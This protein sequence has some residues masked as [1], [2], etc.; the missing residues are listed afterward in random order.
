MKNLANNTWFLV[1]IGAITVINLGSLFAF[2]QLSASQNTESFMRRGQRVQNPSCMMAERVGFDEEQAVRFNQLRQEH[3]QEMRSQRNDLSQLRNELVRESLE[4]EVNEEKV[5]VLIQDL[6]Q[7]H[8][9]RYRNQVQ[10]FN[11]VKGVCTPKQRAE[12]RKFM[13]DVADRMDRRGVCGQQNRRDG[14]GER[15]GRGVR[16]Q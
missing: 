14:R 16:W 9:R 2:W 11:Q 7:G 12:Y 13:L 8:M 15:M 5:E 6:G 1:A 4:D 3:R 10:H